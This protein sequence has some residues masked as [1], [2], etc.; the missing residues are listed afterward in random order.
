MPGGIDDPRGMKPNDGAEENTPKY[1]AK[2]TDSEQYSCENSHRRQMVFCEP[3]VNLVLSQI[4]DV[5]LQCGNILAQRVP[6]QD[7]TRMRPPLA[8]ARGVRIT[9]LV[10][11]LVMFTMNGHPQQRAAL[12]RRHAANR[13][14]VFKPLGCREGAMG[15]Q[16]VITDAESQA[17]GHP[18]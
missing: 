18:E 4:G 2:S 12:D 5:A 15:E 9:F 14:K 13:K 16:P 17:P 11:V 7:P 10:G 6:N 8:I 3:D 1:Q